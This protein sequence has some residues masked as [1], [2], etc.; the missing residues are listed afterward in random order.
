MRRVHTRSR[1]WQ[2]KGERR[3]GQPTRH[4][5]REEEGRVLELYVVRFCRRMYVRG[6]LFPSDKDAPALGILSCRTPSADFISATV[7]PDTRGSV[8]SGSRRIP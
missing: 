1:D 5:A 4:R 3:G 7:T 6:S 2:S 8:I